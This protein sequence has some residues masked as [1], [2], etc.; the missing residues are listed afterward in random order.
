[1]NKPAHNLKIGQIGTFDYIECEIIDFVDPL[2]ITIQG[3]YGKEFYWKKYYKNKFFK[4]FHIKSERLAERVY[5]RELDISYYNF[6]PK[7]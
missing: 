4:F 1:M 2:M 5:L 3:L 6:R 7:P